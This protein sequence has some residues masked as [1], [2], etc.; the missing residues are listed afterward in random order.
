MRK[1]VTLFI[2]CILSTRANAAIVTYEMT[3]NNRWDP[4]SYP[5]GFPSESHFSWLGG[6]THN[7]NVSFWQPGSLAS[8]GMVRMAESGNVDKFADIEVQNAI[9]AGNAFSKIFEK[10]Y[11]P[12]T[13]PGPGSR[14]TTFQMSS[15]YPLLTLATML[16]P[17]PDWFVGVS[18]LGACRIMDESTAKMGERSKYPH[19]FVT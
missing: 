8:P 19:F 11:T 15:D 16:G 7:S 10:I 5:I 13:P 9:D 2:L 3:I 12:E 6:G 18:G 1:I 17:S 4:A 14:V